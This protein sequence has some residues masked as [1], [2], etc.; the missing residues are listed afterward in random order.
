MDNT[1]EITVQL[2]NEKNKFEARIVEKK[3]NSVI[4]FFGLQYADEIEY[5]ELRHKN[6]P[7]IYFGMQLVKKYVRLPFE[8]S[9]DDNEDFG[10][11]CLFPKAKYEFYFE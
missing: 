6:K 9:Y 2:E 3:D 10:K 5:N 1:V 8:N 11:I 4:L 7:N